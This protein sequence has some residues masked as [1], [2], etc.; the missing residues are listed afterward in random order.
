MEV[1]KVEPLRQ[2][3][4]NGLLTAAAASASGRSQRGW[5]WLSACST[6]ESPSPCEHAHSAADGELISHSGQTD[7][8]FVRLKCSRKTLEKESSEDPS[9]AHDS[10]PGISM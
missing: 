7:S 3:L 10:S 9:S 8:D 4:T 1:F 5:P 2:S 6:T